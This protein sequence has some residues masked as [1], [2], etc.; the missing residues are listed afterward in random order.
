MDY[1][2]ETN[3]MTHKLVFFLQSVTYQV[4]A[5]SFKADML[6]LLFVLF[7]LFLFLLLYE[8]HAV[9]MLYIFTIVLGFLVFMTGSFHP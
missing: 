8:M 7:Y 5:F 3:W 4:P 2:Q 1:T 6:L 9:I